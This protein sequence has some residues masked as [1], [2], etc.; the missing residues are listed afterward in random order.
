M[1]DG[2]MLRCGTAVS[3]GGL[4]DAGVLGQEDHRPRHAAILAID[5]ESGAGI[6]L[7][8]D[9]D[10]QDFF[11]DSRQ[12]GGQIDGG[13]RLADAAFLVGNGD[14]PILRIGAS[15]WIRGFSCTGL[16]C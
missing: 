9:V 6:A 4:A 16:D 3:H 8:I 5:T 7:R 12:G 13:G 15:R 11:A 2:M 14:Y 1:V 10:N